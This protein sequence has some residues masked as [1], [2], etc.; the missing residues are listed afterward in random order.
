MKGHESLAEPGFRGIAQTH[1]GAVIQCPIDF[2][3]PLAAAAHEDAERML[4][5]LRSWGINRFSIAWRTT[6]RHMLFDSVERWGFEINLYDMPDIEAFLRAALM[7]PRS[8]TADFNF[9]AWQYYGRGSGE[10]RV[11]H[12]YELRPVD[13]RRQEVD[14]RKHG[15]L[16]SRNG[17]AQ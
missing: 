2:L 5:R 17:D 11:D 13:I 10:E 15:R 12:H 9:P 8:L 4:E 1:P 14:S 3:A 16:I 7:L 6:N